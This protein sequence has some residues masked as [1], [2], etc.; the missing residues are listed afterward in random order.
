MAN[1]RLPAILLV[2]LGL[3]SLASL[4]CGRSKA[5]AATASDDDIRKALAG[6]LHAF[7]NGRPREAVSGLLGH[8]LDDTAWSRTEKAVGAHL[9]REALQ[10]ARACAANLK[11]LAD[12]IELYRADETNGY[13]MPEKLSSIIGV[14]GLTAIPTCPSAHAATYVY[15]PDFRR[16]TFVLACGGHHHAAAGLR[17]Y[18]P[19]F[20]PRFG[21]MMLTESSEAWWPS[22]WHADIESIERDG[23]QAV[24][25]LREA[26]GANRSL[27][28]GLKADGERW[29][30][31]PARFNDDGGSTLGLLLNTYLSAAA[32]P[33]PVASADRE[34]CARRIQRVAT[35]LEAWSSDHGGRY[36][37]SLRDL[38]PQYL[39]QI[40]AC[41][42]GN[43]DLLPTYKVSS[44]A[45]GY[46]LSCS[47]TH[48]DVHVGVRSS[49]LREGPRVSYQVRAA[50]R[51]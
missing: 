37:V 39:P 10:E 3:V 50:M 51:H 11:Q 8:P 29:I 19:A 22:P 27:R 14:D 2:V 28:L 15:K 6:P 45:S 34:Q 25:V 16:E 5:P 42:G 44:D 40:P 20:R 4:G 30:L 24:A 46:D 47:G 7:E 33:A 18:M 12:A 17:S 9:T 31:D 48:P 13:R 26:G 38:V 1:P 36:P 32:S 23:H 21:L 49:G 35:A 41:S 43:G